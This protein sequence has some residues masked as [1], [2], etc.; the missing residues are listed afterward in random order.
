[1][2]GGESVIKLKFESSIEQSD[3]KNVDGLAVALER[4]DTIEL[5]GIGDIDKSLRTL[6][7]IDIPSSLGT[8]IISLVNAVTRLSEIESI[9]TISAE[10]AEAMEDGFFKIANATEWFVGNAARIPSGTATIVRAVMDL[11]NVAITLDDNVGVA[12]QKGFQAVSDAVKTFD[13]RE[14]EKVQIPKGLGSEIRGLVEATKLLGEMPDMKNVGAK[15]SIGFKK[16]SEA[17]IHFKGFS[18]TKISIPKSIGVGVTELVKVIHGLEGLP[19]TKGIGDNL[20]TGFSKI[21]NALEHFKGFGALKVTIPKSLG[22]G[23][24]EMVKATQSL[25]ALNDTNIDEVGN[26]LNVGFAKIAEA[27]KNFANFKDF[28]I[29]IPKTLGSSVSNL[30][31]ALRTM[32]DMP[33]ISAESMANIESGF[34]S[35][36]RAVTNFEK[37]S[38]KIPVS[39]G[40]GVT[41]IIEAINQI[42]KVKDISHVADRLDKN[43]N[44]IARAVENFEF[45][46]N[47]D[48]S[49]ISKL[50]VAITNVGKVKPI[51]NNV[52]K[53]AE[54]L[55]M[56][57]NILGRDVALDTPK[58]NAMAN[59]VKSVG[60]SMKVAESGSKGFGNSLKL[61]NFATFLHLARRATNMLRGFVREISNAVKKYGELQNSMS[62]FGRAMG[63]QTDAISGQIAEWANLGIVDFSGFSN[64]VAK[65][66]QIY[67]GYGISAKNAGKMALNMTQLATDASYAIGENGADIQT[68]YDRA[69]SVATG[70]TKA[71][72]M[73]GVDT[74]V[75]AL[76]EEFESF[77]SGALKAERAVAAYNAMLQNTIGMQGQFAN[78]INTTYVQAAILRNQ[79]KTL[80][81]SIGQ[82]LSPL[83]LQLIKIGM[84]VIQVFTM[85]INK[86]AE[87]F[88]ASFKI[89]DYKE[90]LQGI[91]KSINNTVGSADGV[92]DGMKDANKA[93]K[94]LKKTITSIDQVFT[95]NDTVSDTTDGLDGLNAGL[96]DMGIGEYEFISAAALSG[97]SDMMD[98]VAE[99]AEAIFK[100]LED[101]APKVL[102]IG[103]AFAAWKISKALLNGLDKISGLKIPEFKGVSFGLG[104]GMLGLFADNLTQFVENLEDLLANGATFDNVV[105]MLSSFFSG[106]GSLFVFSGAVNLGGAMLIIGGLGKIVKSI[107]QISENGFNVENTLSMIDGLTDVFIGIGAMTGNMK[108][109]GVSLTLK[110]AVNV[111][112]D[113]KAI[114]NAFKTSDW[115]NVDWMKVAIHAVE[116]LGG[117][118]IAIKAFT[119]AKEVK[120]IA[121][122]TKTIKDIGKATEPLSKNYA[123]M[124][125]K[126]TSLAKNLGIGL[127]IIAE[128]AVAT[129]LVAGTVVLLGKTLKEMNKAWDGVL[130]VNT[131]KNLGAGI[132]MLGAVGV[133]VALLGKLGKSL[134]VDIAIGTLILA[135]IGIAS[136]VFA[137]ELYL[138]GKAFDEV[139]KAWKPVLEDKETLNYA[140]LTGIAVLLAVGVACAALGALTV[141][142]AGSIP[143]A[144]GV[145]ALVLA[146]MGV[147][148]LVFAGALYVL[149]EAFANVVRAW[150]PVLDNEDTL[151]YAL[152]TGTAVLLAVGV[153]CAALG[154][155]TVGTIGLLPVAIA[156]GV[157]MLEEVGWAAESFV[158]QL[159]KV[160][161]ALSK[162][163]DSWQPLVSQKEDIEWA[164]NI[165]SDL[166]L[167]VGIACAGI[168][169]MQVLSFGTLDNAINLGAKMLGVVGSAV[170]SFIDNLTRISEKFRMTLAPELNSL[171]T[172]FPTLN[173]DLSAYVDNMELFGSAFA[174]YAKSSV[175][176]GIAST[177]AKIVGFFSGDPIKSMSDTIY[178]Q[179]MQFGTMQENLN[180]ILPKLESADIGM[181]SYESMYGEIKATGDRIAEIGGMPSIGSNMSDFASAL[182]DSFT[183]IDTIPTSNVA[184]IVSALQSLDLTAFNGIGVDIVESIGK[185]INDYEF[186]FYWLGVH[187]GFYL[188]S[189][190]FLKGRQAGLDG[191]KELESTIN[192]YVFDFSIAI[193][194]MQLA[195][196]FDGTYIGSMI[197]KGVLNGING[198]PVNVLPFVDGIKN[199]LQ[200]EFDIHSPSRWGED[201]AG[202]MI[203]TGVVNG[204]NKT[205]V[206]LSPFEKNTKNALYDII[207]TEDFEPVT[208]P[209][210]TVPI[211]TA[212]INGDIS[213]ATSR[214]GANVSSE[215]SYDGDST[216]QA[217]DELREEMIFLMNEQINATKN[218]SFVLDYKGVSK[219]VNEE[220]ARDR[221]VR[222]ASR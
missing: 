85:V 26:K 50:V 192:N 1:M 89:I 117:L 49:G 157:K 130:K 167:A 64:Q 28:N 24:T 189:E 207:P 96:G 176:S 7:S 120:G 30:V 91:E 178:Y 109:L 169:T 170:E 10:V 187:L 115:E 132:L 46:G 217:I 203:G 44:A 205:N 193:Y 149:G 222:N 22:V 55:A 161:V 90:A 133:T 180:D 39:L 86:V 135:E 188:G 111:L 172:E 92:A 168:G 171:A 218:N 139:I 174:A 141:A 71:G 190:V 3:V 11:H 77:E 57:I 126:L 140:L 29:S 199:S 82:A 123:T 124:T 156:I 101:I 202:L 42:D 201:F 118:F 195:L 99:S 95:I 154:A 127:I 8:S 43:F 164:L 196:A 211:D 35:I 219:R 33:E 70:Q 191:V 114:I 73:F 20:E 74:S 119:K 175:L 185:G 150:Q 165:G 173:E 147:A 215:Y 32:V 212:K 98:D 94:E 210:K 88:G 2:N 106:I 47:K 148:A 41:G 15:L 104:L 76:A 54:K 102:L 158:E 36:A 14:M 110:G 153:A 125:K 60:N 160:G 79:L 61:I 134:I 151:N 138:I 197:A 221:N 209:F 145:G 128:V 25:E 48:Y 31:G 129:L 143:I 68:W 27:S 216:T 198:T 184:N 144:I 12:M 97:V 72:Y 87:V 56:A 37:I 53:N 194:T 121:K 66:S 18:D 182:L 103:G 131:L 163:L 58:L 69:T 17:L 159:D 19:D 108:M 206:D 122:A 63:D 181:K 51:G 213:L 65:L 52:V 81:M 183:K 208:V 6:S 177:I 137:G 214:I 16:I 105:G 179:S 200:E 83:F 186:D 59:A 23:I 113:I 155:L 9:G 100:V 93:A 112:N 38:V 152:K 34:A 80:I 146:E 204:I 40:K 62:F 45:V 4:L 78:E 67:Q 13:A 142:T 166:L 107:K 220:N 136:L 75:K 84:V 162:M 21:R 5:S 116:L